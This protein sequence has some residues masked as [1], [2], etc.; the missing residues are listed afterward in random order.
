MTTREFDE[1]MDEIIDERN[2]RSLII[3]GASIID[4]QLYNILSNFLI[5][6]LKAN[7]DDLLK[8][9]NPLSTFSSRIKLVHRLGLVDN[10]FRLILDTIR[11]I[12][13]LCAHSVAVN[14]HKSPIKE[15]LSLLKKEIEKRKSFQLTKSRYFENSIDTRNEIKSLLVTVCVIL[16]A[17]ET[18][19]KR[20][21][22]NDKTV[23][24]S[25]K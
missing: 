15:Y 11:K 10:E 24:I 5:S 17:I 12:R 20:T 9:D 25:L 16:Q 23:K 18:S 19:T 2:D 8:G 6:P 4:E 21:K 7:E 13:N 14:I 22:M 3:L 1:L